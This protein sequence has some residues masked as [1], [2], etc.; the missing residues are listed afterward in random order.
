M[1]RNPTPLLTPDCEG[2]CWS[3]AAGENSAH[4]EA[5]LRAIAGDMCHAGPLLHGQ[6]ETSLDML[7]ASLDMLAQNVGT[8][9]TFR[10]FRT[11]NVGTFQRFA[12][13][14]LRQEEGGKQV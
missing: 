2:D 6:L 4:L 12:H 5:P 9:R 13:L 7:G 14:W 3:G 10:T 11:W 8:Y 1:R